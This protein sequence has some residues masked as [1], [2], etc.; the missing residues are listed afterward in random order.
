M[1]ETKQEYVQVQQRPYSVAPHKYSRGHYVVTHDAVGPVT[2]GWTKGRVVSPD[3]L[4]Q[5]GRPVT[6]L[7]EREFERLLTLGAIRKATREEIK[8]H[9]AA[10]KKAK[11]EGQPL[12]AFFVGSDP[13]GGI[14][15]GGLRDDPENPPAG[16]N[17]P[18]E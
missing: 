7:T 15:P 4:H 11:D 14:E 9:D 8:A 3:D 16:E 18:K 13:V 17:P 5:E 2:L 12:D 6:H 1:A 10:V